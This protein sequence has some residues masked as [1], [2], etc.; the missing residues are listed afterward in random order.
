MGYNIYRGT[1]KGG[2]YQKLN[3]EVEPATTY[4]DH[5]VVAGGKYFYVITSVDA[6]KEGPYSNEAT[7]AVPSP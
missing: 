5:S 1:H 4:T 3:K 7:A 2:P 6:S